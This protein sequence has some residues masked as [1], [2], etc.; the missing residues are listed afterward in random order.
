[1]TEGQL[2]KKVSVFRRILN[3]QDWSLD[4][5]NEKQN[6]RFLSNKK[7][8]YN[9][10]RA[11]VQS[12][13]E[14]TITFSDWKKM[15]EIGMMKQHYIVTATATLHDTESDEYY[16]IQGYGEGAD[17][18]DKAMS[19]A[20]TNAYKSIISNNFMVADIDEEGEEVTETN[21]SIKVEA[22]SGFEAKQEITKAKV[23]RENASK[24][25][26]SHLPLTEGSISSTQEKLIEK[27][28]AKASVLSSAELEK[29]G[30]LEQIESDRDS[31]KTAEDALKFIQAYQGVL[32]CQ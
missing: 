6:Y 14:W 4:G 10:T 9:V 12:G 26:P 13:L 18:G 25:E 7:M 31:V 16:E 28:M 21:D 11:L 19:K 20:K 15:D 23:V 8:K 2:F 17:S 29:F 30:S 5:F 3:E 1:M 27:I 24:K 32:R 22:R